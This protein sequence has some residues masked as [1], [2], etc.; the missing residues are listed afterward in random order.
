MKKNEGIGGSEL[1]M[2][3][4]LHSISDCGPFN[5]FCSFGDFFVS[6][7]LEAFFIL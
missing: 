4:S 5:P 6:L 1:K 7:L 2:V 3:R